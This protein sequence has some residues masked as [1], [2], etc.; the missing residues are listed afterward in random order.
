MIANLF[1]KV[2]DGVES[3]T[4]AHQNRGS[5]PC[6][7]CG[8]KFN[9]NYALNRHIKNVHEKEKSYICTICQKT[10]GYGAVGELNIHMRVVHGGERHHTCVKCKKSFGSICNLK[11]HISTVHERERPHTCKV[12]R[13][14]FARVSTLKRH[15]ISCGKKKK[16]KLYQS[17]ENPLMMVQ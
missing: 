4:T 17:V 7:H 13:K 16:M 2:S 1:P 14:P 9:R 6:L 3:P 10:F 12:C 8:K 11:S 5:D 15:T